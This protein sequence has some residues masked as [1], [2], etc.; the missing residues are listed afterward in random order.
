MCQ[1][2]HSKLPRDLCPTC[3]LPMGGNVSTLAG[4]LLGKIPHLCRYANFG[5]EKTDLLQDI[6]EHEKYCILKEREQLEMH[7][8]VTQAEAS[9]IPEENSTRLT[10]V[11]S[12]RGSIPP[13]AVRG[14]EDL[15]G[16]TLYIGRVM[17]QGSKIPGK[18]HL[19]HGVVYVSW[20]GKEHGKREYEVLVLEGGSSNHLQW[21]SA[22]GGNLGGRGGVVGGHEANGNPLYIGRALVRNKWI[23]GKISTQYGMCYVPFGGKE[24]A[25]SNYEVLCVDRRL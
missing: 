7:V 6:L 18:L 14:G 2:C 5:C 19:S 24:H 3:R 22:N 4:A 16:E 9:N 21:V 23:P 17:H 10:F 15:S 13:N 11:A 1:S 25:N 8:E 20:G 12:S